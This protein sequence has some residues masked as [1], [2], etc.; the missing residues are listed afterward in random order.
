MHREFHPVANLF[1]LLEGDDFRALCRDIENNGLLVPIWLHPDGRIIDGRNRYRACVETMVPAEYRT[2]SG[3]GSLVAFAVSLNLKRRHLDATQKAVV[4][5]DILPMLEMEAK[6]RMSR[7]GEGKEIFPYLEKGQARDKAA[8]ATGANPRYVSDAKRI[9]EEAPELFEKMRNG[10][11]KIQ[12]AK[13]DLRRAERVRVIQDISAKS[14]ALE[15]GVK[16]PVIYCDPPWRYEASVSNTRKIENHYP[17]MSIDEICS[18]S[19]EDLATPDAVLF[20]WATNPK[21]RE[22]LAAISAWGFTYK[23]NMC[24]DKGKIG[25][26][27]YA[28]QQHELL[29]IATRG[30]PP[31]PEPKNRPSSIIRVDRGEHSKKP[32]EA[33]TIIE[34][35][36]PE[37][38]KIELFSRNRR[39]GWAAWGNQA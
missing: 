12:E 37:Y 32:D 4:S 39:E 15:T 3:D 17:T 29:L 21:L 5:V 25:M 27:Y 10:E 2:W 23:T 19:V 13:R 34:K 33:Y 16:Y 38:K 35:M 11:V 1:P 20:M 6:A 7:G 8:N 22:A 14:E 28:R 9:K 26:G 30:T 24:W 31:V 36:Y 18:M